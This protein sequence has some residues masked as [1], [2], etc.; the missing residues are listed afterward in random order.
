[1]NESSN[2]S[3]RA[4]SFPNRA[5]V[6]SE[7]ERNW[8][9]SPGAQLILQKHISSLNDRVNIVDLLFLFSAASD[10]DSMP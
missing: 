8:A 3:S 1:V 9:T 10:D 4:P 2:Q 6:I 5:G 7:N